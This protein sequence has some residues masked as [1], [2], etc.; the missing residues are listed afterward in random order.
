MKHYGQLDDPKTA[1]EAYFR[2]CSI[3]LDAAKLARLGLYLANKGVDPI[4]GHRVLEEDD[5][6]L[7]VAL[8]AT[9][10][11]Y[12]EVGHFAINVG[13]PAKS[14]VSGAILAIVPGRMTIAAFGPALGP[15]GNSVAGMTAMAALSR[16]LGLSLFG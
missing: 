4:A 12:D 16:R 15:K 8:M 13:L 6:R 14:G 7:I 9:C 1:A 2:Q 5:N 11:L 10:G 3:S